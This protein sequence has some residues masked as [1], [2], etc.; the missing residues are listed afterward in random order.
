MTGG[1]GQGA[2]EA[3]FA[4]RVRPEP[5]R[6]SIRRFIALKEQDFTPQWLLNN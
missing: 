3:F 5:N 2:N 6:E 1:V 4:Q